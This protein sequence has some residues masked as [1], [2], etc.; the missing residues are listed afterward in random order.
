MT[1]H[2]K[3]ATT[4]ALKTML[5]RD[6]IPIA[7][8]S[9]ERQRQDHDHRHHSGDRWQWPSSTVTAYIGGRWT[10]EPRFEALQFGDILVHLRPKAQCC[11]EPLAIERGLIKRFAVGS[12]GEKVRRTPYSLTSEPGVG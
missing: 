9:A 8:H 3:S 6:E 12:A 4:K 7:N 1:T 11:G 10:A 2:V 5:L